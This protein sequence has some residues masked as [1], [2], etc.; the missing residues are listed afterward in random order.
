MW[1]NMGTNTMRITNITSLVSK[2]LNTKNFIKVIFLLSGFTLDSPAS[3]WWLCL[4]A[5]RHRWVIYTTEM[6]GK[7]TLWEVDS[8][9]VP[10]EWYHLHF[11][12]IIVVECF[13]CWPLTSAALKPPGGVLM[14]RSVASIGWLFALSVS[15]LVSL[16]T[17]TQIESVSLN[18][19]KGLRDLFESVPYF[20]LIFPSLTWSPNFSLSQS[21]LSV[22]DWLKIFNHFYFTG[23]LQFLFFGSF[24]NL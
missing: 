17:E 15:S 6:N 11:V 24:L 14:L 13:V 8:S 20:I 5:G 16:C 22:C 3:C 9:M 4:C 1:I 12:I 7:R 23:C 10:A 21:C 2:C 18:H 19:T